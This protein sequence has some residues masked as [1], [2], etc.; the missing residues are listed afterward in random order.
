MRGKSLTC[1]C[2]LLNFYRSMTGVGDPNEEE[3]VPAIR[4]LAAHQSGGAIGLVALFEP[5]EKTKE[6]RGVGDSRP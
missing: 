1:R 2:G 6:A 4:R 5:S 3:L